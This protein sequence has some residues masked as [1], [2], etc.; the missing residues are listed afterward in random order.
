MNDTGA[1][2]SAGFF[3]L[4]GSRISSQYCK[5]AVFIIMKGMVSEKSRQAFSNLLIDLYGEKFHGSLMVQVEHLIAKYR[6]LIPEK[7]ARSRF[8]ERDAILITYGDMISESENPPL[9]ALKDFMSEYA[10]G[11]FN[12]IHILPF[13]QYSSD[14]GFSV[15]DFKMV[16]P[17][18]G[19]WEHIKEISQNFKLMIDLVVNH[20][21]AKSKWFQGFLNGD[22]QYRDFFITVDDDADLSKVVRP[23]ALPL[24]TEV[25]TAS[26]RKR[27]WTTFSEDQVDLNYRNPQVLFAVLDI[28]LFYVQM[29]ADFIRLDA[30]AYIWKEIGTT[31]IHL[32]QVHAI[33]QLMRSILDEVAPWVILVTETNVPHEENIRYFGDGANEAQMVY[34]FSLPPL[35][36]HSFYSGNARIL[37][38]WADNLAIPSGQVAFFNF[39]ASHDGIGITPARNILTK[40][41]VNEIV[42]H[43]KSIGGLISYKNTTEGFKSPYE[44]NINYFDALATNSAIE[45][46]GDAE[47]RRFITSHAIILSL[48][49][50]P[51]IYFHS[52]VGSRSWFEGVSSLGYARAINREKLGLKPLIKDMSEENNRR[53]RVYTGLRKLMNIRRKNMAFS[54]NGQ[55]R[56]LFLDPRIFALVRV[57]IEEKQKILCLHNFSNEKVPLKI[58]LHAAGWKN[59]I[60]IR[61]LL[62]HEEEP[63]STTMLQIS[64]DAYSS[65]WFE[66]G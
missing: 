22:P 12:G 26:G 44:L 29:G 50:V 10:K 30:V 63:L 5:P 25:E 54:P 23:R 43:V 28:L 14:D 7:A 8:S 64:L 39:L 20:V 45:N 6:Q 49:G 4:I 37:S 17:A 15:I 1:S 40:A 31:C 35:V 58:D 61:D 55:Q 18:V 52:L 9:I 11:I 16:N 27:V 2:Y 42:D 36:L 60:S 56:V 41:E 19:N 57:D 66:I 62:N 65:T 53:A 13:F 33:V 24:V 48:R 32:P 47:I 38:E 3:Y 59:A 34:N 21:S 51:G 46:A